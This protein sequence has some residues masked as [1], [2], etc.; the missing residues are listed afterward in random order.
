MIKPLAR[1]IGR[2]V[3]FRR[4]DESKSGTTIVGVIDSLTP[5][6]VFVTVDREIKPFNRVELEWVKS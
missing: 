5:M 3:K 2:K 1:D 4:Y 6:V